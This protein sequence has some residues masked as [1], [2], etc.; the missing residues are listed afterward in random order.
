MRSLLGEGR[1]PSHD[2]SSHDLA[3]LVEA[4][5]AR[6]AGTGG[7]GGEGMAGQSRLG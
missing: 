7:V 1:K 6:E 2:L 5:R 3:S 4:I